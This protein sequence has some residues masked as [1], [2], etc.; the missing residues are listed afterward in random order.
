MLGNGVIRSIQ[1]HTKTQHL[2][3]VQTTRETFPSFKALRTI[4]DA[5]WYV[6][7]AVIR[8]DLL[9][10]PTVKEVSRRY[11]SLYSAR[12]SAYPNDLIVNLIELPDN[13]IAK[14][15]AK[16][17]AYQIPSVIVVFAILVFKV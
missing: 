2:P 1:L 13:R 4:V 5:P 10:I 11:S 9:H 15:P 3:Q 12:L 8:R 14:I 6:P 16:W 7:N 17:S